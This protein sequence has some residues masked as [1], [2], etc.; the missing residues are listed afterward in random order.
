MAP[1]G[2]VP[3]IV[4]GGTFDPVHDGHLAVARAVRDLFHATVYLMPAGDPPHRDG[5][6][7]TATHR[8]AMLELAVAGEPGLVVDTRE[9]ARPGPSWTITTVEELRRELPAGT[10][11][12]LVIG[13]D[14]LRQFTTWRRWRDILAGAHLV[15]CA[16]PGQALPDAAALGELAARLTVDPRDL[17]ANTGGRILIE[18]GTAVNIAATGI[19]ATLAAGGPVAGIPAAVGDYIARHGLYRPPMNLEPRDPNEC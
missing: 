15:A 6:Q 14:S 12:I 8:R 5:P 11:L 10:P 1:E 13:M 3:R 18:A 9:L 4:L 16:R 7:A 17:L 19:R 2:P